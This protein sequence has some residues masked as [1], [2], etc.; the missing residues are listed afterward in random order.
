MTRTEYETFKK[1]FEEISRKREEFCDDSRRCIECPYFHYSCEVF[2]LNSVNNRNFLRLT[3]GVAEML[4][5][6][7]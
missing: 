4:I 3:D 7:E 1:V 6:E 2:H 5:E